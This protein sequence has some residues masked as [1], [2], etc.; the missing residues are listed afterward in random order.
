M[1]KKEY[2][3][4]KYPMIALWWLAISA[5][6]YSRYTYYITI[7]YI[8]L[9]NFLSI[10]TPH[11]GFKCSED[12]INQEWKQVICCTCEHEIFTLETDT[13]NMG[14]HLE[15]TILITVPMLRRILVK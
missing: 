3:R 7:E 12:G 9:T 5:G 11:F 6:W 4:G 2:Y 1:E 10:E 13:S 8:S 15:N 14:Y